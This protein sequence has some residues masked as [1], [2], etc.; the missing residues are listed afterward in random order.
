MTILVDE[1]TNIAENAHYSLVD[2]RQ[3]WW[4][5]PLEQTWEGSGGD[6][7]HRVVSVVYGTAPRYMNGTVLTATIQGQAG[8]PITR[9]PAHPSDLPALFS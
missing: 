2:S 6:H 9:K 4:G 1:L 3:D 7:G 5:N 8:A